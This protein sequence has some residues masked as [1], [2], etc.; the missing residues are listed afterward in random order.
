MAAA[1]QPRRRRLR[2]VGGTPL[3]EAPWWALAIVVAVLALVAYP[4]VVGVLAGAGR[5]H[6]QHAVAALSA[7]ALAGALVA[8]VATR[9]PWRRSPPTPLD[10]PRPLAVRFSSWLI[11]TLLLPNVLFGLLVLAHPDPAV[12]Y[13]GVALVALLVSALHGAWAAAWR[14]PRADG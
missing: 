4:A 5:W 8:A 9:R 6:G 14:R 1:P 11:V 2:R 3:E 7:L 13:R 10:D 12:G